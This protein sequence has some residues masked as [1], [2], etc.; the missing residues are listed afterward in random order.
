[1]G[2]ACDVCE[3]SDRTRPCRPNCR[4]ERRR[5]RHERARR[6][7]LTTAIVTVS[8]GAPGAPISAAPGSASEGA[9]SHP[10][11]NPTVAAK[12]AN[13]TFSVRKVAAM[14]TGVAPTAFSSPTRL[15]YSES[16]RPTRTATLAIASKASSTAPGAS[17]D[18]AS[19]TSSA[20]A[21]AMPSQVEKIGPTGPGGPPGPPPP[22]ISIRC[23]G[24]GPPVS[25]ERLSANASA[26]AGS[27]SFRFSAKSL[28]GFD[29]EVSDRASA[30]VVQ[31]R[32]TFLDPEY[33]KLPHVFVV[34]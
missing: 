21:D 11:A 10:A 20:S 30:P 25:A 31:T 23:R 13:A 28:S 26:S 32:P 24:P 5:E 1:M 2:R 4:H 6:R 9:I 34:M 14:S 29:E 16:R 19:W 7:R 8:V 12:T 18:C 33:W 27:L 17:T 22:L 3:G 15:A